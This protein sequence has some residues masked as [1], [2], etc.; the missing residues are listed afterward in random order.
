MTAD[1]RRERRPITEQVKIELQFWVYARHVSADT[2]S[3]LAPVTADGVRLSEVGLAAIVV[4]V[5]SVGFSIMAS[6]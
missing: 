2:T 4:T 6:K 1:K 5:L 3:V